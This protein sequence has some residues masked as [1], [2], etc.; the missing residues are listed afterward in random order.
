[1]DFAKTDVRVHAERGARLV[2]SDPFTGKP[3]GTKAKPAIVIVRGAVSPTVQASV[4][5][6]QKALKLAEETEEGKVEVMEDLHNKLIEGALPFIIGF[7]NVTY[8][9][10]D[11]ANTE[12]LAR[13][14]LNTSFPVMQT[15]LDDEG[16]P[17]IRDGGT[18]AMEL[19][20]TP[21]AVQ[22]TRFAEDQGNFPGNG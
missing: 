4:R 21:F 5:E 20:N 3:L 6:R 19:G 1:M 9:D 12:A 17:I 15:R 22:V 14:V 18:P 11:P 16:E 2:L 10:I 8:G 7:E 13:A